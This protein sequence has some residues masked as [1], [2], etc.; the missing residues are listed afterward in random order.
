MPQEIEAV[1]VSFD[2]GAPPSCAENNPASH[3]ACHPPR[4]IAC[5]ADLQIFSLTLLDGTKVR[6]RITIGIF[7]GK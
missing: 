7:L 5:S 4:P 6:A 1:G 3:A 2:V